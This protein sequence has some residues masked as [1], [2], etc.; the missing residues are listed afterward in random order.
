MISFQWCKEAGKVPVGINHL[1]QELQDDPS[2]LGDRPLHRGVDKVSK[3][4]STG[5]TQRQGVDE[6]DKDS[7]SIQDHLFGPLGG[8]VSHN[9]RATIVLDEWKQ[10]KGQQKAQCRIDNV[11]HQIQSPGKEQTDDDAGRNGDE[12]G[13]Y[14][15]Y[16]NGKP[17][18]QE[19][20]H[21][22]LS[23][24]GGC[25]G[26]TLTRCQESN[27]PQQTATLEAGKVIAKVC[28]SNHGGVFVPIH[29][30]CRN[31]HHCQIHK[32]G[33]HNR[34]NG[35]N[36]T[37]PHRLFHYFV[38]S[39]DLSRL[40]RS[41]VQIQIVGHDHGSNDTRN[42]KEIVRAHI[43]KSIDPSLHN[44]FLV[45]LDKG[46]FHKEGNRHDPNKAD[47]NCLQNLHAEFHGGQKGHGR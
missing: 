2:D 37:V 19:A 41:R 17:E 34:N 13:C 3:K 5:N 40:D 22:V 20:I 26:G 12:P 36:G 23:R 32:K 29:A 31:R 4:S 14:R 15:P 38:A 35:F 27:S 24:V 44:G 9:T 18:F 33:N 6:P 25:N 30:F 7:K 39:D 43:H 1:Q 10:G 47:N 42:R 45:G 28:Q 46:H 11:D 21:N 16:P 8:M